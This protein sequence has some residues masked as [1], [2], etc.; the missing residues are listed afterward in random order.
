MYTSIY[1]NYL[2]IKIISIDQSHG[3]NTLSRS[4][5]YRNRKYILT[6]HITNRLTFSSFILYA[7]S[8]A[9]IVG[10]G[11]WDARS[12]KNYS[13]SRL[14]R[15][16]KKESSSMS[17]TCFCFFF[18]SFLFFFFTSNRFCFHFCLKFLSLAANLSH[19]I[20]PTPFRHY[21]LPHLAVSSSTPPPSTSPLPPVKIKSEPI[22]PP[23]DPHGGSS[24][25]NGPSNTSNLHHTNLSVGPSS[26]TGGPPPHHVS[27]PGPQT[28]N[29]VS[30]RPSSNPPPSHSG[31]I[32]PTNL[33]SPGNG[34]VGD[35][36]TNHSSG[37]GNGG[38]SS[39]YENGPLMKRSRITEGWA[40]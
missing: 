4:S 15:Y 14:D 40:T 24:G 28:L 8:H 11:D 6:I 26:S 22:S 13:F 39:D 12:G 34:A 37:G 33:P 1:Q 29:L 9:I 2:T 30:N 10:N 36:R 35:I 19:L 38:N 23:R 16:T 21:S 20:P 7:Q 31:S 3:P 27:H 5:L 25:S 18:F 32:T 17:R